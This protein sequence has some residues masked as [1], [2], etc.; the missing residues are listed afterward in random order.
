MLEVNHCTWGEK[1]KI[2]W[3]DNVSSLK[4]FHRTNVMLYKNN[5]YRTNK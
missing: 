3:K 1:T 2:K 4:E 5:I